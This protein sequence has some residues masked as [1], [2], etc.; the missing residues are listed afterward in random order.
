MRIEEKHAIK[1]D[2]L[3]KLQDEYKGE[4]KDLTTLKDN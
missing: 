1:K 2:A 4:I 3:N